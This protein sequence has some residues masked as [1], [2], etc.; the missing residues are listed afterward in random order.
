MCKGLIARI[1]MSQCA[2]THGEQMVA[3][4]NHAQETLAELQAAA[5]V[6]ENY[7]GD[8][9]WQMAE[10]A[11]DEIYELRMQLRKCREGLETKSA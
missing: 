8:H 7:E 9:V 6:L 11:M 5:D 2:H 10:K 1:S 3:Q 4:W